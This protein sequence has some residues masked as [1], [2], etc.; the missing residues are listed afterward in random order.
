MVGFFNLDVDAVRI[1]LLA[2]PWVN[3]VTV[4]RI[5]PDS[6]HVTVIEQLPAAR[7]KEKGLLNTAG[8]YFEP[9][10]ASIPSNLPLLSGPAKALNMIY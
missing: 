10:A 8:Q 9:D 2:E 5:W 6:I 4:K 7:W 3:D 1:A